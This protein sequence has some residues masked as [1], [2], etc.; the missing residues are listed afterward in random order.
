MPDE[1]SNK[2][3]LYSCFHQFDVQLSPS[4]FYISCRC[5]IQ[6]FRPLS[7]GPQIGSSLGCQSRQNLQLE[8]MSSTEY[9]MQGA[10]L[11]VAANRFHLIEG[12]RICQ[13]PLVLEKE[14]DIPSSTSLISGTGF[15]YYL[16]GRFYSAPANHDPAR[17]SV[18]I[19]RGLAMGKLPF[20]NR[21]DQF[22]K[23]PRRNGGMTMKR[24][25]C[26]I[27]SISIWGM[28]L[29]PAWSDDTKKNEIYARSK[30]TFKTKRSA[31][32]LFLFFLALSARKNPTVRIQS[33][34][35]PEG[36]RKIKG[37]DNK[38]TGTA[39]LHPNS[40]ILDA[41]INKDELCLNDL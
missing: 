31:V 5:H 37:E 10:I 17:F 19:D 28:T 34:S 39:S 26:L 32:P 40:Q 25:L 20:R 21:I 14:G 12:D 35:I 18:K 41:T 22:C 36:L 7:H 1:Y 15:A 33:I 38:I 8:R 13:E 11:P 16:P 30:K 27:L 2:I 4:A 23:S 6:G 29:L 9:E 24:I 3:P